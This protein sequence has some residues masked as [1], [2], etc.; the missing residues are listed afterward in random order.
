MADGQ[1]VIN[2]R[3]NDQPLKDGIQG[4]EGVTKRSLDSV[5]KALTATGLTVAVAKIVKEI[6]AMVKEVTELTDRVDKQSQKIGLSR[7]AYQEWDYI[8]AQTGANVD[9]LQM[10]MKTL[11]TAVDE[12][13]KGNKT[14]S[15]MLK[16]LGVETV[17]VTG[18]AKSQEQIF[19]EVFSALADVE[20]ETERTALASRLL[21]RS[22]TELAPAMNQGAEAIEELRGEAHK[23]GIV[24]EDEIIDAGVKLNDNILRLNKAWES[25]KTRALAP[26]TSALVGVTDRLLGQYSASDK[27][28]GALSRAES[29]TQRY[30]KAQA[31]AKKDTNALTEAIEQQAYVEM[32]LAFNELLSAW[33]KAQDELPKLEKQLANNIETQEGWTKVLDGAKDTWHDMTV[34]TSL[35]TISFEEMARMDLG[36]V[37]TKLTEEAR[38]TAG[39]MELLAFKSENVTQ[40]WTNAQEARGGLSDLQVKELEIDTKIGVAKA[41]QTELIQG[42][43]HA[44][45]NGNEELL[46]YIENNTFLYDQVQDAIKGLEIYRNAVKFAEEAIENLTLTSVELIDAQIKAYEAAGKSARTEQGKAN[47]MEVVNQ[48]SRKRSELLAQQARDTEDL[49]EKERIRG[50]LMKELE[51]AEGRALG[52]SKALGDSYDYNGELVSLY[53]NAIKDLIDSGLDPTDK[54]ITELIGKIAGLSDTLLEGEAGFRDINNILHEL[55]NAIRESGYWLDLTG[56]KHAELTSKIHETEKALIQMRMNGLDPQSEEYQRLLGLL[57]Q[58]KAELAGLDDIDMAGWEKTLTG[59]KKGW[60]DFVKQ[61][62]ADFGDLSSFITK[63]LNNIRDTITRGLAD[64]MQAFFGV[65]VNQEAMILELTESIED[66]QDTL[67]DSYDDLEDAQKDYNRAV[68]SGDTR[69]IKN[70]ERRLRQQEKL[71]KGHEE[72]LKSLKEEKKSVE[73]GSKAWTEFGKIVIQALAQTLYGLGAELLAR[74]VLAL[75]SWN[76][77]GAGLAAA[78]GGVAIAAGAGLEAWA[79]SFA[80][81]GIV[82]QV[83]GVPSY[84]DRHL[85][86]VNPGEL[87]LNQSQQAVLAGQL[88]GGITVNIDNVYGLDSSE[89][90]QAV[91]RNIKTLQHEGVLGRW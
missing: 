40:A 91:Y 52:Y 89:V 5:K 70:A 82:P 28:S 59:M 32:R 38:K 25:M 45:L 17:D 64:G 10:S 75:L 90:G 53:T 13:R 4:L 9:G 77:V 35:A 58:Y 50:E 2:T 67:K 44:Y 66:M 60:K 78:A 33:T 6:S 19:R 56:D 83:A 36:T 74:S 68:L 51:E 62:K 73:D 14:Y 20:D 87:I 23:L 15:E 29:A 16:R 22:A 63:N 21:G 72:S 43:A 80:E 1:V 30:K 8:L 79:G 76:F 11:S 86:S 26:L 88:S 24:Y 81:G 42:V 85:A 71:V 27:L 3:L 47:A 49:A 48:L 57:N 39:G 41:K 31:D 34:G 61:S 84:G 37:M 46:K 7:Q 55:G 18:K 54:R 12:A 65:L 69:A